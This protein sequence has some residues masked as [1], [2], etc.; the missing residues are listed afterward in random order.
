[1][2]Q[3]LHESEEKIYAYACFLP[4]GKFNSAIMHNTPEDK[5]QRVKNFFGLQIKTFKR[6]HD[7]ELRFKQIR[8]YKIQR[9]FKKESSVFREW[10]EPDYNKLI[11]TDLE[12]SKLAKFLKDPALFEKV[13]AVYKEHGRFIVELF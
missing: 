9:K 6:E 8:K 2:N 12:V 5:H 11:D 7:I 1:M 13:S 10:V 4:A 3:D